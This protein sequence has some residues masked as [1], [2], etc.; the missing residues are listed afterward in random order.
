MQD[1]GLWQQNRMNSSFL[2]HTRSIVLKHSRWQST[3]SD[4]A[5]ALTVIDHSIRVP[6]FIDLSIMGPLNQIMIVHNPSDL[7]DYAR[8]HP[9][10]ERASCKTSLIK[11]LKTSISSIS[12][13]KY[14]M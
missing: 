6:H 11:P 4:D 1:T 8:A 13:P 5:R 7:L 12:T 14:W 3:I 10:L 9:S 2:I